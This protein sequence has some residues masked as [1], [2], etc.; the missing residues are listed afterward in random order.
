MTSALPP[1]T[2]TPRVPALVGAVLVFCFGFGAMNL[3]AASGMGATNLPGLYQYRSASV[4]DGVLLPIL[5]YALIR[6]A[7]WQS[8]WSVAQRRWIVSVTVL[9][10]L[11]GAATQ[12]WWLISPETPLNWTLPAVHRF[13]V[14]GWYHAGFLV[15]ASGCFAGAAIALWLRVRQESQTTPALPLRRLRATGAAGVLAPSTAFV[16]L[17]VLDNAATL[18]VATLTAAAFAAVLTVAACWAVRRKPLRVTAAGLVWAIPAIIPACLMHGRPTISPVTLLPAVVAALTGAFATAVLPIRVGFD[19]IVV[20]SATALTATGPVYLAATNDQASIVAL[21]IGGAASFVLTITEIALFARLLTG[22]TVG[23]QR[24]IGRPASMLPIP[25]VALAARYLFQHRNLAT[26]YANVLVAISGLLVLAIAIRSIRLQF[27][28]VI[29]AE[30]ADAPQSRLS[31]LKWQAYLA[32]STAFA[33][34]I[35]AD[36]LIVM[37]TTP[38][39]DWSSGTGADGRHAL[40]V[41]GVL[42]GVLFLLGVT[43]TKPVPAVVRPWIA[44]M[45]CVVWCGFV[46]W[47][48]RPGFAGW[49]GATF[50]VLPAIVAALFVLESV[51]CNVGLLHNQGLDTPTVTVGICACLTAGLT[52]AWMAGPALHS[53][54]G[55]TT[56]GFSLTYLAIG[57]AASILIPFLAARTL[58]GST[59]QRQQVIGLPLAGVLQDSFVVLVLV[60]SVGWIPGLFFAH[61]GDLNASWGAVFSY[62]ALLS[63]A[64][65]WVMKNNVTH[66]GRERE[67]LRRR[68]DPQPLPLETQ[69]ALAALR[70]HVLHQNYIAALALMPLGVFV[71]FNEIPGLD[72]SGIR[73]LWHV[74]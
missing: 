38:I 15:T 5:A 11:L 27:A 70:R 69:R 14:A 41:A 37:A 55:T 8:P 17:L 59:P 45:C 54:H 48:L 20:A 30:Q 9:G 64:Y 34:A 68:Y 26:S 19:R 4:G 74:P 53:A 10:A 33:A 39:K 18:P 43:V 28:P 42:A 36:L 50:A 13:N 58:P 71:L 2:L 56:V 62:L 72:K 7:R 47:Q 25:T 22:S 6:A 65:V 49:W 57:V 51:I 61:I 66:V 52:T 67:R 63:A 12:A 40:T 23:W 32:I 3:L 21:A 44:A 60:I 16:G 1:N 35:L 31:M 46:L 24:I 73:Q 29:E